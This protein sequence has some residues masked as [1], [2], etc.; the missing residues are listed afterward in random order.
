MSASNPDFF[1][2]R[3]RPALD[4]T[5]AATAWRIRGGACTSY[6]RIASGHIDVARDT[7]LKLWDFAPF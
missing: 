7:N 4:A 2:A 3:E 1:D 5:R 6:G